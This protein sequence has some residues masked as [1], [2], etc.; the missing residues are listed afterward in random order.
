[1]NV[2]TISGNQVPRENC[3]KIKGQFYEINV[4]CFFVD[5]KWHRKNNGLI[6]K[7]YT[8][9]TY[10][11]KEYAYNY[12]TYGIVDVINGTPI[13]G[14]FEEDTQLQVYVQIISTNGQVQIALDTNV[15]LEGEYPSNL[16]DTLKNYKVK[17]VLC[18]NLEVLQQL[19]NYDYGYGD[20][21]L[22]PKNEKFSSKFKK[23]LGQGYGHLSYGSDNALE[24][25][26]SSFK[27]LFNEQITKEHFY[28]AKNLH[29]HSFGL[30][31]E[32]RMGFVSENLLYKLGLIPVRD[33]SLRLP[34]GQEPYEFVTVPL[35]NAKGIA[36]LDN[37]CK[38]L[39]ERTAFDEKC[40]LHLHL[41]NVPYDELFI[42]SFVKLIGMVQEELLSLFP[43]Y[44]TDPE[45]IG[46]AKNYCKLL[47]LNIMP[48]SINNLKQL[49]K[50]EYEEYISQSFNNIYHF[51]SDGQFPTSKY[52][53]K[54]LH[55]PI[56]KDKWH[57][58]SRYYLI[59]LVP[60]MFKS[61]RT[62]EFRLHTPTTNRYK[63]FNWMLLAS[64]L[65]K[66]AENHTETVLSSDTIK[67]DQVLTSIYDSKL[68]N[69]LIQYINN[70]K[71]MYANQ[72]DPTGTT[73]FQS[74][75]KYQELKYA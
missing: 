70:R 50:N 57:I 28:I 64:A 53:R 32:T 65:A 3:R 2:K 61:F 67:L 7:N 48:K 13:G 60:L 23:T 27:K 29:Q 25:A 17:S 41:G 73:E 9:G 14:F 51:V 5:N 8:T 54:K 15:I 20:N 52:N 16:I 40:S 39:S 55:H 44:K 36:A 47:P 35:Q 11:K 71:N 30:E 75:S 24:Y 69:R 31:F 45:I 46:S 37:I 6:V 26:S 33:G 38:T 21:I 58:K 18:R 74:D 62:I 56:Q 68:S 22:Y 59:N 66:Y 63:V 1:M 12:L 49:T 10:V 19:G 42:I 34:S 43:Y 4:D 72:N